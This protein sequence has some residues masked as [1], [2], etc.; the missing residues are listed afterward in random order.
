MYSMIRQI[1]AF[2]EKEIWFKKGLATPFRKNFFKPAKKTYFATYY[3]FAG[4]QYLLVDGILKMKFDHPSSKFFLDNPSVIYPNGTKEWYYDNKLHR[5]ND[6]P[7]IEYANGDKEWWFL[8]E[9]HPETIRKRM[10]NS[11]TNFWS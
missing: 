8:G 7:A 2:E 4:D 1:L 3:Y 10:L 5:N 11:I 9:R 6:L